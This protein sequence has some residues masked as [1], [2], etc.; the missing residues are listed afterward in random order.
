MKGIGVDL[1]VTV[2]DLIL[3]DDDA[4]AFVHK[5]PSTP[6]NPSIGTIEGVRILARSAQVWIGGFVHPKP[7]Y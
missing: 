6:A 2:T 4:V 7:G 3:W 1:E 5:M